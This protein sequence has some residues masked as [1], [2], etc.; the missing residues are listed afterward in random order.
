MNV[1]RTIQQ[2]M[3]HN[4]QKGKAVEL[5]YKNILGCVVELRE[6]D[7]LYHTRVMI[8]MDFRVGNWYKLTFANHS[9]VKFELVKEEKERPDF[10]I[11]AYDIE[12]TKLPLKFPDSSFD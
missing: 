4:V 8:D 6:Y 9:V 5:N 10:C 7:V 3:T 2:K 12:T 11:L 1:R